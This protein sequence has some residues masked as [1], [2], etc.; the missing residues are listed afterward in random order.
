MNSVFVAVV[1]RAQ[2]Y[3]ARNGINEITKQIRV[4]SGP[5]GDKVPG[6]PPAANSVT[7]NPIYPAFC[8]VRYRCRCRIEPA[9]QGGQRSLSLAC[10]SMARSSV[11]VN[12]FPGT[13]SKAPF[14]ATLPA[15]SKPHS[16]GFEAPRLIDGLARPRSGASRLLRLERGANDLLVVA[17]VDALVGESRV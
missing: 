2:A 5:S 1:A 7:A 13:P 10:S 11:R 9:V 6:T 16:Q 4:A 12:R 14:F 17:H 8:V 15:V 3:L